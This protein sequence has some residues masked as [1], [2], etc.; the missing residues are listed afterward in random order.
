[1]K[2]FLVVLTAV[3]LVALAT[4]VFAMGPGAGPGPGPKGFDLSKDQQDKMWQLREKFNSDTSALRYEMFQK[5]RE[6][7]DLYADPKATDAAILA[8]DKEVNTLKQKMHDKMVRFK[9]DQRKIFTSEQLQKF[10]EMGGHGFGGPRGM[11][12]GGFGPRG[13]GF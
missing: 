13:C 11:G 9:L 12:R 8:K 1:M 10:A 2:K 5:R 4:S 6:L 7:R 3:L